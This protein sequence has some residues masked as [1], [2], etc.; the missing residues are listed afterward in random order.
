MGIPLAL[1]SGMMNAYRW[2]APILAL[3]MGSC[4]PHPPPAPPPTPPPASQDVHISVWGSGTLIA[5]R[6]TFAVLIP[7]SSVCSTPLS[8]LHMGSR[9]SVAL[10]PCATYG[11]GAQLYLT[12]PEY[13]SYTERVVLAPDLEVSMQPDAPD[14]PRLFAEGQHF[15]T[16]AG[17][18]TLIGASGFTLYQQFLDGVNITPVLVQLHALGF[19]S[20]R[21]FGSY[22]N[23]TSVGGIGHFR[24][25]QYGAVYWNARPAFYRLLARYG[26]YGEFVVF[27]DATKFG[28]GI[29]QS[30]VANTPG[31][32]AG[33]TNALVEWVNEEDQPIN[34][35]APGIMASLTVIP[36]VLTSR[37]SNGSQAQPLTP[38]LNYLTFHTNDAFEEQRK[39]GHNCM[40]LASI[41]CYTNETSRARTKANWNGRAPLEFAYDSAAGAALLAAGSLYH[42]DAGKAGRVLGGLELDYANAWVA[43]ATSVPLFCQN[44]SYRHRDDLEGPG[45]LRAYQR[46]GDPVCI[47]RIR[48]Q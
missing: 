5:D 37:G 32:F 22:D 20:V 1:S 7:E 40:E 47:V 23:D 28:Q 18:L 19:N 31:V 13:Q 29:E 15:R 17:P 16:T 4:T 35:L 12:A 27:A 10:P 38:Y 44:G 21:V 6:V 33:I 26:L 30:I 24:P 41:P 25:E 9:L 36:G 46:G 14:L 2:G 39:I 45:I 42:S 11:D 48:V 43:G 8:A 34:R 3:V